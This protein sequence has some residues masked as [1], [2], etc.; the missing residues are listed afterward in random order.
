MGQLGSLQSGLMSP[1][2]H[3]ADRQDEP[4][5]SLLVRL[6]RPETR[7]FLGQAARPRGVYETQLP[8]LLVKLVGKER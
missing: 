1:H 6:A 7:R 3:V 5:L 8:R 4:M 2:H